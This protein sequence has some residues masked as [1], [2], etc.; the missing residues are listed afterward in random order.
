MLLILARSM[1]KMDQSSHFSPMLLADWTEKVKE[2]LKG[3]SPDKLLTQTEDG[4][5]L[6]PYY[7]AEALADSLQTHLPGDRPYRRG[8]RA[9]HNDWVIFESFPTD[10]PKK[11]NAAILEA[12]MQ[13]SE[14]LYLQGPITDSQHF[15]DL[16]NEILPQ[17]LVLCFRGADP[18]KLA[19]WLRAWADENELPPLAMRGSVGYDPLSAA[20]FGEEVRVLPI[21]EL[22]KLYQKQLPAYLPLTVGAAKFRQSGASLVQELGLALAMG[23]AY[24]QQLLAE[25]LNI[26]EA[27]PA[28]Q[29]ELAA[30][31][32]Y[33]AEI[34]KFRAF[35]QLWAGVVAA[36]A[37]AHSC[38]AAANVIAFSASPVLSAIDPHTNLLRLTTTAMSAVMGGVHGLCLHAYDYPV[39][40]G[41]AFGSEL[42]RN[43]QLLLKHEALLDKVVDPAAGSYYI[44]QL[45]DQLSDKAWAFF[46][47]I[48]ALGGYQAVVA[49]G[50]LK[51]QIENHREQLVAAVAN[52]QKTLVGVN[53]YPDRKAAI[54]LDFNNNSFRLS[55]GFEKLWWRTQEAA[56]KPRILLLAVGDSSTRLS[57]AT[58]VA[59]FMAC[60]G[61]ELI[62]NNGF[63]QIEAALSFANACPAEMVV[64]CS[65]D[66]AYPQMV[67]TFCT[68]LGKNKLLGLAGLPAEAANYRAAGI[69]FFIHLRAPLLETLQQLQNRLLP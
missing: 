41:T 27:T 63:D 21:G 12:L 19:G 8:L 32:D 42:S 3:A 43:I 69:D 29:F 57:R 23:N 20:Y 51:Q 66:E 30:A 7:T 54:K 1:K 59:N 46:Q 56:Q 6:Q 10:N 60:A 47:E 5:S 49:S 17:Y 36:Y 61:F 16:T 45:T 33:F 2:E 22:V 14:G 65:A 55:A 11:N 39:N 18:V 24:I 28:L 31:T 50:W 9:N 52:R 25:G 40:G 62:E 26:D 68:A 4:L 58:F 44:E 38:T 48:E 13:G 67:P 34:A 37:P 64:L 15:G 53:Q 35:R